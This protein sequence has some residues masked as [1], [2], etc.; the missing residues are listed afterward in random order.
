VGKGRGSWILRLPGN[1][2]LQ[3]RRHEWTLGY[4]SLPGGLEGLEV[5][6][7]SDLH[8]APCYDRR[9]FEKVVEACSSWTPDLLVITGDLVDD[10]DVL[11]WIGKVLGPLEARIGKFAILGNHDAECHMEGILAELSRAGFESL[12][13]RWSSVLRDGA[14]IALGGTS[15]P[16]GPRLDPRQIPTADFRLLLSH[17]PDQFYVASRWGID[18]VLCGHNHGGQ[19]RVPGF[20]PLFMPSIYSRR[21]DRGFFQRGSML[22]YVNEGVG[23]MHP[24]RLG[25]PPEVSHLVLTSGPASSTVRARVGTSGGFLNRPGDEPRDES[26]QI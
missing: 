5:L 26:A 20:G 17:S 14:R 4:P 8:F 12:E 15:A 7:I 16:W 1:E 19:I 2:S 23:G 3:L 11:D 24:Y 10:D 9:Y 13:G 22:M 25:C 18:L 6:Q 21:F